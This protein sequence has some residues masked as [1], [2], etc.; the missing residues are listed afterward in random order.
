[1]AHRR[2]PPNRIFFTSFPALCALQEENEIF[3]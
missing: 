2:I 3:T 1:V